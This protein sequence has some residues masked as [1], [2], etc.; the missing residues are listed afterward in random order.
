MGSDRRTMPTDS[1][2][3][4]TIPQLAAAIAGLTG[5]AVTQPVLEV[6]GRNPEFFVARVHPAGDATAAAIG[7]GV[8]LPGATA[9]SVPLAALVHRRF[10]TLAHGTLVA[11]LTALLVF[12]AL[13]VSTGPEGVRIS[14]AAA[15]GAGAVLAFWRWRLWRI[16]LWT[17]AIPVASATV[18][19]VFSPI[20]R[21]VAPQA[22]QPAPLGERAGTAR[23]IPVTVVV[24]DELPTASLMAGPTAIDSK[25]FPNFAAFAQD[26]VWYRN[27]TTVSDESTLAVPALLTG[28]RPHPGTL[29]TA[30]DHPTTLLTL[31]ARSH[32]VRAVEPLT[33]LC[34]RPFCASAR[35]GST[36]AGL[37]LLASDVAV[38][39][40]HVLLP[41]PLINDLPPIDQTWGAFAQADRGLRGTR[42]DRPDRV[43][44]AVA[45]DR[46][47]AFDRVLDAAGR[48]ASGRRPPAFV[49]HSL[50]PHVPYTFLPSGQRLT[51]AATPGVTGP[52]RPTDRWLV[53]YAQRRH[54]LQAGAADR[55]LGHV[56]EQLHRAGLYRDG[57]VIVTADHGVAFT[58][59]THR[60][61]VNSRTLPA[62]AAVPLF[63]KYPHRREGVID[64]GPAG[65]LDVAPTVLDVLGLPVPDHMDGRS[66][67]TSS[68]ANRQ[69]RIQSMNGSVLEIPHN[70]DPWSV[71]SQVVADFGTGWEGVYRF[72]TYAAL[73]DSAVG[74]LPR[75]RA[76]PVAGWLG[77]LTAIRR[78]RP[79]DDPIPAAVGGGLRFQEP[80][81]REVFVGVVFDGKIVAVGRTHHRRGRAARFVALTPP[82]AYRGGVENVDLVLLHRVAERTVAQRVILDPPDLLMPAVPGR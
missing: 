49:L 40:A 53:R 73:V 58:P 23:A 76:A 59:G 14:I 30:E 68:F 64:P 24:F 41:K 32:Q 61:V 4:P 11:L 19:L 3:H 66:L 65:L 16:G 39:A 28:R 80:P 71:G 79:G 77:D 45:A 74:V 44:K 33:K 17:A 48:R 67:H 35:G 60:R 21:I 62:I 2:A 34:A 42:F 20:S 56:L 81:A 78:A 10:G 13:P 43:Q 47:H 8:L 37:P 46:R 15:A 6:L 29:P 72:G 54:L 50:L 70:L 75:L 5:L 38:V 51:S 9:A 31:L 7:L 69:R 12:P 26:A 82:E 57:L 18:F 52:S 22:E 36:P 55:L 25:R 1:R 27:A 63:I